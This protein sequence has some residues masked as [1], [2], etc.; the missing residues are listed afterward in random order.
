M[1]NYF[2]F[3]SK[4][5]PTVKHSN[6]K[7]WPNFIKKVNQWRHCLNQDMLC[8]WDPGNDE[9]EYC[10]WSAT[11][12]TGI[13]LVRLVQLGCNTWHSVG[14]IWPYLEL[15]GLCLVVYLCL[16][17]Q[18]KGIVGNTL[19]VLPHFTSHAPNHIGWLTDAPHQPGVQVQ[20]LDCL[21]ST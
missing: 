19:R 14:V 16:K 20:Y 10:N 15:T 17:G 18:S 21:L 2:F 12:S 13:I 1:K 5:G 8:E 11:P 9:L 3:V 7:C 6:T 4:V